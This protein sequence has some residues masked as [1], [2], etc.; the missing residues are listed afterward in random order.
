MTNPIKAGKTVLDAREASMLV[1]GL[2]ALSRENQRMSADAA[3][4]GYT[5]QA[6]EFADRAREAGSL[7]SLARSAGITKITVRHA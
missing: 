5:P 3:R 2:E 6:S 7:A 4:E 1:A